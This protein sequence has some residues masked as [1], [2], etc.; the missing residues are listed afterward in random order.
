MLAVEG[1][2]VRRRSGLISVTGRLPF[3]DCGEAPEPWQIGQPTPPN[4]TA[5]TASAV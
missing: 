1:A 2:I 5:T 3:Q 4:G